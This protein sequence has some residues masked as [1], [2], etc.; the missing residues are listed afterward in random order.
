M[1]KRRIAAIILTG[2]LVSTAILGCGNSQS[3]KSDKEG[4]KDNKEQVEENYYEK[5][6]FETVDSEDKLLAFPGVVGYGSY[7]KGGRGGKVIYVTNLNDSGEGSLRA[8]V[9]AEG[10]RVILFKVSGTIE[11]ETDLRITNPYC[12]I[13]GQSAPGDGICL[14]NYQMVVNADEVIVSYLR[15]RSA[16]TNNK[17]DAQDALWIKNVNQVVANHLSCS[18]AT[19]EVLSSTDSGNITIQDC[20][21]AESLNKTPHGTHGMGSILCGLNGQKVTA[22]RNLYANHRNRMPISGNRNGSDVDP[23]GFY[24]EFINNVVYNWGGVTAGRNNDPEKTAITHL[25]LINNYYK[26]GPESEQG[27]AWEEG[28][29][30]T[31]MYMSGNSMN[32]EIPEDQYSLVRQ[33]SEEYPIDWDDYIVKNRFEHSITEKITTAA[34]AYEYVLENAGCSLSRDSF[35]LGVIDCVKNGT[36]KLI[37]KP[38][39][40]AGW[41]GEWPVLESTEP[42]PDADGDGMDDNWEKE[43]GL[44]PDDPADGNATVAGGYTNLEVFLQSLLGE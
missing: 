24:M 27:N 30:D 38:E 3:E 6:G 42:Y 11:L 37:N 7:T 33:E 9:E 43:V 31:D 36:G 8:A 14:K 5:L 41:T 29:A 28:G 26:M 1:K 40:A 4:S 20:I 39:E 19:D 25:N 34:E 32:G 2:V 15:L 21:I 44:N 18:F 17:E 22:Y 16:H 35:D 12:T 13:A 10:P 23:V